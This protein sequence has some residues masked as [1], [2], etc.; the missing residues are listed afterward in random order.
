MNEET[1]RLCADCGKELELREGWIDYDESRPKNERAI[2][3]CDQCH[4]KRIENEE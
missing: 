4:E 2:T 1:K 3:V